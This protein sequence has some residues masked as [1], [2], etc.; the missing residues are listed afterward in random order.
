MRITNNML[1]QNLL[2]NLETAQGRIDDLQDQLSSNLRINKPSDDP[3]GIQS[4]MRL[5]NT[6]SS[7][8]QWKTNADEAIGYMNSTDSTLGEITTMLQRVRELAVEGSNGTLSG[9]DKQKVRIEVDQIAEHLRLMANTQ[10]G[11][12]Y[13]FSGTQTNKELQISADGIVSEGND[14]SILF[15]VGNN[16][17]LPISVNGQ[18]LFGG[19]TPEEPAGIFV[20]L[21]KLSTALDT[22]DA[23]GIS[24]ALTNVDVDIDNVIFHRADL[25]A[26]TNRMTS[27][28]D[29][30]DATSY[31]LQK[32]LSD[33]M[34]ADMAKTITDFKNQ[35][36]TYKAA[37]SVGAQIIQPSLVDFI[38]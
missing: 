27:L 1:S 18:T 37:L 29:Q 22:N 13:I 17:S 32:N 19:G 14:Q 11:S 28:R 9:D 6:I 10:I 12:K 35:E 34:D 26:R 36:N 38:R 5:Q 31:N 33:I 24:E 20:T 3:I 21:S 15:E 8:E 7:V 23:E 25:G 2:R 16:L 4:S 30:L